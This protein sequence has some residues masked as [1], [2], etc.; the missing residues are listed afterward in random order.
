MKQWRGIMGLL[1]ASPCSAVGIVLTSCPLIK[2]RRFA[3]G[4]S[5]GIQPQGQRIGVFAG[6]KATGAPRTACRWMEAPNEKG[7]EI[8]LNPLAP[9]RLGR[10]PYLTC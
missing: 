5:L 1:W 7:A 10:G 3:N 8:A 9:C 2:A 4:G 6:G